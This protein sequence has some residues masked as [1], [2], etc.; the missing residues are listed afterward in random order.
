MTLPFTLPDWLPDWA[1][2]LLAIPAL[3]FLFAFLLM[4][5]SVFGVKPR[6]EAMEAQLDTLTEELRNLTLSARGLG[7]RSF[8]EDPGP[9]DL[10]GFAQPKRAEPP[11]EPSRAPPPPEPFAARRERPEARLSPRP[12]RRSEPRLD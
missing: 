1:F 4:P 12:G 6:L 5:F 7:G 3:L 2:L 8:A 9:F 10:P 11:P